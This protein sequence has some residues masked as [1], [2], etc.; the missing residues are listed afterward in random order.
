MLWTSYFFCC[1]L[2]CEKRQECSFKFPY[3][4]ISSVAFGRVT[5]PVLVGLCLQYRASPNNGRRIPPPKFLLRKIEAGTTALNPL[6]NARAKGGGDRRNPRACRV[7][8]D[9][10]FGGLFRTE[11]VRAFWKEHALTESLILAQDERWRRVLG[12]QVERAFALYCV[13]SFGSARGLLPLCP[14]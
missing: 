1:P 9:S 8:R 4:L 5:S 10:V 3:A 13:K 14:P 2:L 6:P 12:M 7:K 11:C